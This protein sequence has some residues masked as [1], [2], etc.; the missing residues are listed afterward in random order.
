M[1][2]FLISIEEHI[3]KDFHVEANDIEEAMEIA[4]EK[5][6]KGEFVVQPGE[7]QTKLM[8]VYEPETMDNT[9]WKEF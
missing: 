9:E 4:E 7:V 3:C 8:S 1:K 5:Y 2:D 6:K